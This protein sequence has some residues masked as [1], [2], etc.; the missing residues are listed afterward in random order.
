MTEDSNKVSF[1]KAWHI[2]VPGL[3][4]LDFASDHHSFIACDKDSLLRLFNSQGQELWHRNAGQEII[5]VSLADTL[6]VLAIDSEKHSMLFG[7]EGATLWRKRPFPAMIGKISASGDSFAFVTSDPA[8]IGAD[9]SLR[10][11]WA[12]RNLM[13]RP[14][15]IAISALGQTTAF[16]CCDDRGEGLSAVNHLGKPYDAFMGIGTITELQLS[17]DGQLVIAIAETGHTF[18]LNLVKGRGIWKGEPGQKSTGVSYAAKTGESLVYS[19]A[20]QIMKLSPT[21]QPIWEHWFPDRLLK[22]SLTAD[23]GGIFYATERGEIGFLIQSDRRQKN[24]MTFQEI[25]VQPL[26]SPETTTFR[27]V[28]SLEL[29]GNAEHHA[30]ICT[31][32]GQ[33]GVEYSLVWDG[34][35][36]LLCLNDIGEEIWQE[37]LNDSDTTAMS[38]SSAADLAVIVTRSGVTGY[39]LSGS[40]VFRLFG[41][42]GD[43]H[44][45][46]DGAILL[47]DG[48]HNCRFYHA[49][50]HFSHQLELAGPA[51]QIIPFGG[52]A[53]IRCE[54]KFIL[55]DNAG[56]ITAEKAFDSTISF[57]GSSFNGEFILCGNETGLVSIFDPSLD[58]VFA[59]RLSGK[60]TAVAYNRDQET[61]FA[62][63][64]DD[65]IFVLQ[66]RTGQMMRT[67]LTGRP[68]MIIPHEN[69]AVVGTDLDQIGLI[70]NDGQILMRH[71]L[72]FKLRTLLPSRRRLCIMV[73]GDESV[74]CIATVENTVN[75]GQTNDS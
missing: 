64:A 49:F 21:G 24:R 6:E 34:G 2:L 61:V 42:Y 37:R 41:Q 19:A 53:I 71:T 27:K 22:V 55:I 26:S 33:D 32:A 62:G 46:A 9:R 40:E 66:R 45:F 54:Q 67:S 36:R 72:P 58:T 29:Q 38:V 43:A 10:V 1:Q 18:C 13:K 69:G 16:P 15:D 14:A 39:D 70:N 12:Y 3:K 63:T 11:K 44:V 60:I 25:P 68:A 75:T 7:P 73:L 57:I 17:D 28:W 31:W 65:S 47:L 59:Y 23:G 4:L 50:D 48:A 35:E 8:I 74:G 20:G 5:S 52:Q 30:A 51:M 56:A